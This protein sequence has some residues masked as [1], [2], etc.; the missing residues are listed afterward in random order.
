VLVATREA[1]QKMIAERLAADVEG[2]AARLCWRAQTREAANLV[3]FGYRR[4]RQAFLTASERR[5]ASTAV[6]NGQRG[7]PIARGVRLT[8]NTPTCCGAKTGTP[9]S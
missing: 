9:G 6:R 2:V 5:K 3:T 7:R 8:R 4:E 1:G